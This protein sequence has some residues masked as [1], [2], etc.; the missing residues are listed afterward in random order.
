MLGGVVSDSPGVYNRWLLQ[1]DEHGRPA[2]NVE[3]ELQ[4]L[5]H[6]EQDASSDDGQ[7]D[8]DGEEEVL[9]A[10]PTHLHEG[11]LVCPL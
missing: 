8:G 3:D 9:E 7:R 10:A 4:P 1:E 5:I 11:L 2:Q 6:S